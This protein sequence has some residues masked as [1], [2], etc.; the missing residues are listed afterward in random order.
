MIY[1]RNSLICFKTYPHQISINLIHCSRLHLG[2]CLIYEHGLYFEDSNGREK[3]TGNFPVFFRPTEFGG[4]LQ[5]QSGELKMRFTTTAP[6]HI[7]CYIR[8]FLTA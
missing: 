8:N 6:I 7:L 3:P 5:M 1:I 4:V 2:L